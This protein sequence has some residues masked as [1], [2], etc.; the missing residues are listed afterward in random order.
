MSTSSLLRSAWAEV[1]DIDPEEIKDDSN[2]IELG[3][4]SVLTMKLAGIV[5][6]FGLDLN[7]EAIFKEGVFKDLLAKTELR[8][9]KDVTP[10]IIDKELIEKSA[11]A[12]N[13]PTDLIEDV[14]PPRDTWEYFFSTHQQ[15]DSW[16]IQL[17]FQLTGDVDI[18][19]K[20]FETIHNQNQSFR[21]RMVEIDGQ[22]QTVITKTPIVWNQANDL[23][24]Y[25]KEDRAIKV[26][27]GQ[28]AVRYG[29]GKTFIVWTALHTAMDGWTRKLLCDDLE[30]IL[31]DKPLKS[32]PA[33][34]Q[35]LDVMEK[36]DANTSQAFWDEYLAGSPPH[37]PLLKIFP[38]IDQPM[39][40]KKIVKK[41]PIQVIPKTSIR[42]ST[43]AH[44]AFALLIG[45]LTGDEDIVF[46]GFRA[47]RTVFPEAIMGCLFIPVPIRIKYQP[48]DT[49]KNLLQQVQDDINNATRHEPFAW[50]V[51]SGMSN[52]LG[53]EPSIG[54]N[55]YPKG[56]DPTERTIS[57]TLKVVGENYSPHMCAGLLNA[58]DHGDHMALLIEYDDRIFPEEF[59]QGFMEGY[60]IMLNHLSQCDGKN[61]VKTL[62][63]T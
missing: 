2:F 48:S 49:V 50:R 1:L 58:H 36:L 19:C 26:T 56:T 11:E 9:E 25:M 40:R 52:L 28:P 13:L 34:R 54:F 41:F 39:C 59:M 46:F 35:Y 21:S 37:H 4:D 30:V 32:R 8:Q 45:K 3:G 47:S 17:V 57:K 38:E 7:V 23:E 6:D 22:F 42:L 31:Q 62:L 16:L 60:S 55:W 63:E 51:L 20:A 10:I 43:L 14:F 33:L 27:A 61:Q 44:L 24:V 53:R 29:L 12:C 18:I 5:P 15:T